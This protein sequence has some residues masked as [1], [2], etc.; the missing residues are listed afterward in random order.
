MAALVLHYDRASTL[1]RERESAA[2]VSRVLEDHVTRS[3][4]HVDR[5]L[6]TLSEAVQAS[7]AL[8]VTVLLEQAAQ[9][10]PLVRS[11]SLLDATGLVLASSQPVNLEARIDPRHLE[12]AAQVQ[13]AVLGGLFKGRDLDSFEAAA[14]PLDM[15]LLVQKVRHDAAAEGA[16]LVAA[17]NPSALA[18]HFHLVAATSGHAVTLTN[19]QG[20]VLVAD[21]EAPW[22]ALEAPSLQGHP[23]FVDYLPQREHADLIGPGVLSAQAVQAF[24]A[25]RTRPLVVIVEKPVEAALAIWRERATRITVAVALAWLFIGGAALA[26]YRN[27]RGLRLLG[28]RLTKANERIAHSERDLRLLVEGVHEIMFRTDPLGHVVTANGRW[29]ELTGLSREEIDGRPLA[30]LVQPEFRSAVTRLVAQQG[31]SAS[32]PAVLTV[33]LVSRKETAPTVE[34]SLSWVEPSGVRTAGHA[35][36]AVDVTEREKARRELQRQLEFSQTVLQIV[37]GPLFVKDAQRRFLAVNRAWEEFTGLSAAQVIGRCSSDLQPEEEHQVNDAHDIALQHGRDKTSYELQLRR[38]DGQLR[39]VVITKAA[40]RSGNHML[41]I[42]GSVHDVTD[43]LAAQRAI[44]KARDAAVASDNVKSGFIA[45]V[46][47]E[48]RTPLQSILGFSELALRRSMTPE[49]LRSFLED[50]HASGQRM[51]TLVNELLDISKFES[52]L[53]DLVLQSEDL[54]DVVR[55]VAHEMAPIAAQRQVAL[56]VELPQQPLYLPLHRFRLSQVI[57]NV[58]AN[59][60]RFSPPQSQVRVVLG[61]EGRGASIRVCD[62]GPGVPEA[63]LEA[64]FEPFTQSS[65][66]GDGAGG[67][68]LGLT[69]SRSIMKAHGG[70]IWAANQRDGGAVF[71]IWLPFTSVAQDGTVRFVTTQ[72]GRL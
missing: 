65:R 16:Y 4:D 72:P 30:E 33:Q 29:S 21:V 19:Y 6:R 22:S 1:D 18:N 57:R 9:G 55:Q 63:E 59:A 46:S 39:D 34:L 48:L 15:I 11:L 54:C 58:M 50:I 68:G 25:S 69:I 28:E 23:A 26:G 66:T 64:I 38:A 17:L 42:V 67:T 53:Q 60:L 43:F 45:N 32:E 27:L 20:R 10:Q 12:V 31:R 62:Q 35:G 40:L 71:T 13:A 61:I 5:L 8:R 24:R 7:E 51:L 3:L 44:A 47:H 49:K 70:R 2:M 52:S 36:F 41:G 37:P 56:E 14:S